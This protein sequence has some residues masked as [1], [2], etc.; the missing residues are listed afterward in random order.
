MEFSE[1]IDC[2]GAF[3]FHA[4]QEDR[5]INDDYDGQYK[6]GKRAFIKETKDI[7]EKEIRTQLK[8]MSG[9]VVYAITVHGGDE[10]EDYS[11][12]VLRKCGFKL[13]KQKR[14]NKIGNLLQHWM[15]S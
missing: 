12:S 13:I 2:C 7:L 11:A 8:Y 14:N 5:D 10:S 9:K 6:G 3:I 4:F 15:W 1:F